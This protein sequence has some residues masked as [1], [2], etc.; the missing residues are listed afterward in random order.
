MADGRKLIGS[1]LAARAA[2]DLT[3]GKRYRAAQVAA[4]DSGEDLP[5]YEEWKAQQL[6]QA[7]T[8]LEEGFKKVSKSR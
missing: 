7:D 1:G 6:A 5:P 3:M 2:D 4:I 8:E